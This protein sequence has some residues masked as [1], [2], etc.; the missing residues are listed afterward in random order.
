MTTASSPQRVLT[1][2]GLLVSAAVIGVLVV[3]ALRQGAPALPGSAG[4]VVALCAA[5]VVFL[6]GC[7][8]RAER[9]LALLEHNGGRVGRADAYGLVAVGYVGNNLLPAR[10]GDAVRVV[11]M[12][13]RTHV[14][15][16]TVIGTL[17]A[18]RV[19]D[20]AV[21]GALFLLLAPVVVMG[22]VD[23]LV[24]RVALTALIVLAVIAVLTVATPA[25][26]RSRPFRRVSDFLAPLVAATGRLRGRHGMQMVLWSIVVWALELAAWW[27][28]ARAANLEL[29]VPAVGYL[30]GLAAI[31]VLIPSGPG[32]AGTFDA[33]LIFGMLSLGQPGDGALGYLLLLRFVTVVPVT[34]VGLVA[35][36]VRYGGFGAIRAPARA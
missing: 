36:V 10:A 32:N 22:Q 31:F 8:A 5:V 6:I 24:G 18:E 1:V 26:R 9:W 34:V 3:W 16:R 19:L 4:A 7:G 30:M 27:L 15:R 11:L 12:S 35:L 13:R 33:A 20:T 23:E 25:L 2:L 29:G 14:D 28:T 17:V 21:L